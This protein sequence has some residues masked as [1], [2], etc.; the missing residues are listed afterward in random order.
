MQHRRAQLVLILIIREAHIIAG[1][2]KTCHLL[3]DSP[4]SQLHGRFRAIEEFWLYPNSCRT[5][6]EVEARRWERFMGEGKTSRQSWLTILSGWQMT[7]GRSNGMSM[8]GSRVRNEA[9]VHVGAVKRTCSE[10]QSKK[11]FQANTWPKELF[12]I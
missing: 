11:P 6:K 9:L 3:T 4:K 1:H 5:G 2:G 10:G 8:N 7:R 12:D